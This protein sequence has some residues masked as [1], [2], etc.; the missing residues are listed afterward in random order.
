ME[1]VWLKNYDEGV[2]Q[3]IDYK[4]ETLNDLLD[5]AVRDFPDRTALIFE[6][7]TVTYRQ[8][9]DHVLRFAKALTDL[10]LQ[11]G[12][13][14]ALQLPNTPQF[15]IAFYAIQRLGGT[16]VM[17]NPIYVQRE[18]E[19]I[20][21][22]SEAKFMVLLDAFWVNKVRPMLDKTKLQK[23]V[24][25]SFNDFLPFP[26]NFLFPFVPAAKKAGLVVKVPSEPNVFWLKDLLKKYPAT[27]PD[28]GV[29]PED[30]ATFQYTGGTTG[31]PKAA[32]LTHKNLVYNAKQVAAWMTT[33]V[34]GGEVAISA[35]PFFHSFGLTVCMNLAVHFA[36]TMVLIPDPRN[37]KNLVTAMSKYKATLFPAVP[38][39]YNA[40]NNFEGIDQI[41]ISSIKAC[42]SGAAP[43]PEE[44]Q[45]RFESLTGG[46]IAEGF[47]LSEA[48]PVTHANP[49]YGM[50]KVGSI[51]VP[52]PD[53]EAKIVDIEEGKQELGIGEQGELIIRGPQVMKGYWN[54]PEETANTIRDGWLYTGD[55]AK[56]DEDG[57]FF[58][59]GRKKDMIIAGGYNIY[60]REIDEILYQHPKVLEAAAVG[61]PDPRRG[62]TVKAYIVLKP[63]ETATE[64]EMDKWCRDHLAPYKVPKLYEF[65]SELPKSNVGKVLRRILR[66]E[67][68]EK[69]KKQSGNE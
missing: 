60:P 65:R 54:R 25:T 17:T 3:T 51:G 41:D 64:E 20:L 58:I 8:L 66:E 7:A 67:E 53:T 12:D 37:I 69:Q 2:P 10:G 31:L 18:L 34:R 35:L 16:V 39:L 57:F 47:G 45:K 48:S 22:D 23:V 56:M 9:H 29:T 63:G 1:K 19:H 30:L 11:K 4:G 68:M 13:K 50:R 24:V 61:I 40:V 26:K 44:V 28:N 15:V 55:L 36:G 32:M 6:G 27:P 21:T 14:V 62:E 52:M 59:V 42:V 38:A 33:A 46:R 49:L 5:A 43:L